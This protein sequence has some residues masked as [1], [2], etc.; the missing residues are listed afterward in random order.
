VSLT[1]DQ[2]LALQKRGLR[3]W[4]A[5]MAASSPGAELFERDGVAAA[6]V[7][8]VP[9]RSIPNSASYSDA[10]ALA[11]NLDALA[12]RF[13][14]AGVEAWTVWVPEFDR[15]AIELLG[16]AGHRFDGHPAAMALELEAWEDRDLGGLDW[17]GD[18]SGADLGRLN[19]R[20]YGLETDGMGVA[21][22]TP[23][24]PMRLYRAR[25]DGDV[26]CVLGTIDHGDDLGFY[27][28]ATDPDHRGEGLA[29]R[30]MAVALT[31]ARERGLRT[32]SLQASPMGEP[33][34]RRLGYESPFRLNLYER[35]R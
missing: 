1:R 25:V 7:P 6:I 31:D 32:S 23:P 9:R 24:Q 34:Y 15:E 20:A 8:A 29:S 12:Q 3:D 33:V 22:A 13:E 35:R 16:G 17:D 14:R 11:D 4:I 10:A 26:A 21:L 5:A 28:V 27:F 30:L 19:D 2:V 18:G